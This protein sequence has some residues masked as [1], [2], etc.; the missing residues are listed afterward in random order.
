MDTS[1]SMNR[2]VRPG[3]TRAQLAVGGAITAGKLLPDRSA[4]GLWTFAGKQPGG[5][6]YRT[7]SKMDPL[8]AVDRV[9][10]GGKDVTHRD[11][12][13]VQLL[14]L[15]RRLSPGGTALYD[16]ALAALRDARR[17]YDARATNRVVLFTDGANDYDGGMS[18]S[19]FVKQA[20]AEAAGNPQRP[21][22]L[23]AIGI[24]PDADMKAL[25]TMCAAAGGRAYQAS[26]AATLATVLFDAIAHRRVVPSLIG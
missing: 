6:P 23:I 26:S 11:V 4:I 16:T 2:P 9:G 15:P 8:G 7:L 17:S 10:R 3:L 20:K 5:R 24:G 19:S 14:S 21:V 1:L 25:R 18:L 13:N 22:L 12:V